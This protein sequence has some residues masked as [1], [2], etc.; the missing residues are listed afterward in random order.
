MGNQAK[1]VCRGWIFFCLPPL[2]RVRSVFTLQIAD[3][4]LNLTCVCVCFESSPDR[5]W[6]KEPE[7]WHP[8]LPSSSSASSQCRLS[9]HSQ[10]KVHAYITLL[11]YSNWWDSW[12][13]I[14]FCA[15]YLMC[16]GLECQWSSHRQSWY[17]GK[18][19]CILHSV[20]SP[21]CVDSGTPWFL[22]GHHP[23]MHHDSAV[24]GC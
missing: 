2:S 11:V 22:A 23:S 19:H 7:A 3:I 21:V 12:F 18:A 15:E 1:W 17:I 13:F 20:D 16:S 14:C 6:A 8:S 24:S 10:F 9:S 4:D 5:S